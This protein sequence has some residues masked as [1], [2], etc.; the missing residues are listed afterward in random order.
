M[1]SLI[2]MTLNTEASARQRPGPLMEPRR[3]LPGTPRVVFSTKALVLNHCATVCG[4]SAS[5]TWFGRTEPVVAAFVQPCPAGS[6]GTLAL[7]L[8]TVNGRPEL[9]VMIPEVCQ[10]PR[11]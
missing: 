1:R 8:V 6:R 3:A 7:L 10:P 4:P 11:R 2:L 9:M 5:P